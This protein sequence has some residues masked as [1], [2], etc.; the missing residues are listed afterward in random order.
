MTPQEAPKG[1]PPVNQD[2]YQDASRWSSQARGTGAMA[3]APS[4]TQD[5]SAQTGVDPDG[6]ARWQ[7]YLDPARTQDNLRSVWNDPVGETQR[8]A[9]AFSSLPLDMK[10]KHLDTYAQGLQARNELGA[11]KALMSRV[12]GLDA[13][14]SGFTQ[15]F[16]NLFGAFPEAGPK[17]LSLFQDPLKIPVSSVLPDGS[18]QNSALDGMSTAD[19][20]MTAG[21]KLNHLD[22]LQLG[23]S[24][25]PSVRET[26]K[27]YGELAQIGGLGRV[28][29][30]FTALR[31]VSGL[32][33]DS[34]RG[35]GMLSKGARAVL[36]AAAGGTEANPVNPFMANVGPMAAHGAIGGGIQNLRNFDAQLAKNMQGVYREPGETYQSRMEAEGGAWPRILYGLKGAAEGGASGAAAGA[37]FW[38]AGHIVR[39]TGK[40]MFMP[41]EVRGIEGEIAKALGNAKGT[42][43]QKIGPIVQANPLLK[44]QANAIGQALEWVVGGKAV[45]MTASLITGKPPKQLAEL[46]ENP[47]ITALVGYAWGTVG[48]ALHGK[49]LEEPKDLSIDKLAEWYDS[50]APWFMKGAGQKLTEMGWT[51]EQKV[52]AARAMRAGGPQRDIALGNVFQALTNKASKGAGVGEKTTVIPPL[53]NPPAV[54]VRPDEEPA[55]QGETIPPEQAARR[56]RAKTDTGFRAANR[57]F[58][59]YGPE[60]TNGQSPDEFIAGVKQKT[61]AMWQHAQEAEDAGDTKTATLLRRT[62]DLLTRQEDLSR[63]ERAELARNLDE[64]D[65]AATSE[66]FA[67]RMEQ[68]RLRNAREDLAAAEQRAQDLIRQGYER[69]GFVQPELMQ[70]LKQIQEAMKSVAK[71]EIPPGL[72]PGPRKRPRME[73]PYTWEPTFRDSTSRQ[74]PPEGPPP[75]RPSGIPAERRLPPSTGEGESGG[76]PGPATP[77]E[78]RTPEPATSAG[79]RAR[80]P[81]SSL[82]QELPRFRE[83]ITLPKDLPGRRAY[84]QLALPAGGET[85]EE[86]NRR[87]SDERRRETRPEDVVRDTAIAAEEQQRRTMTAPTPAEAVT[88]PKSMRVLR[89]MVKRRLGS[90][91]DKADMD[92]VPANQILREPGTYQFRTG[93]DK[94]NG[95]TKRVG[96][97]RPQS[98]GVI[99]LH[100]RE[101]GTLAVVNGHNRL[102]S[103]DRAV[104]EGKAQADDPMLAMIYKPSVSKQEAYAMGILQNMRD[105]QFEPEEAARAIRTLMPDGADGLTWLQ[106]NGI[107]IGTKARA[108]VSLAKL[109]GSVFSDVIDNILPKELGVEIGRLLPEDHAAQRQI[110]NDIMAM[111][112]ETGSFPTL[113]SLRQTIKKAA[114]GRE[115]GAEIQVDRAQLARDSA[116]DEILAAVRNQLGAQRA[117]AKRANENA[118]FLEG[119]GKNKIDRE[120]NARKMESIQQ[121][122]DAAERLGRYESNLATMLNDAAQ[123][124]IRDRSSMPTIVQQVS[125]R[126][127]AY[128]PVKDSFKGG[129]TIPFEP[130]PRQETASMFG[131]EEPA[132]LFDEPSGQPI[133]TAAKVASSPE[134]LRARVEGHIA[135]KEYPQ[136]IAAAEELTGTDRTRALAMV[137]AAQRRDASSGKRKK[138]AAAGPVEEQRAEE[139]AAAPV[140]PSDRPEA[141]PPE[142]VGDIALVSARASEFGRAELENNAIV[143]RLDETVARTAA[144]LSAT[145]TPRPQRPGSGAGLLRGLKGSK[146]GGWGFNREYAPHPDGGTRTGRSFWSLV[147]DLTEQTGAIGPAEAWDLASTVYGAPLGGAAD[148]LPWSSARPFKQLTGRLTGTG[149]LGHLLS[150]RTPDDNVRRLLSAEERARLD[151][152]TPEAYPLAQARIGALAADAARAHAQE[153]H[154]A[155]VGGFE[156]GPLNG[157]HLAELG[158]LVDAYGRWLKVAADR[159]YNVVLPVVRGTK[160]PRRAWLEAM[161]HNRFGYQTSGR[162]ELAATERK[163]L[164]VLGESGWAADGLPVEIGDILP[165]TSF[166]RLMRANEVVS[167][168]LTNEHLAGYAQTVNDLSSGRS[169]VESLNALTD[170]RMDPKV[171]SDIVE[172]WRAGDWSELARLGVG[173]STVMR[174]Q[175]VG[176]SERT[177]KSVPKIEGAEKL[178]FLREDPDS[179][180]FRKRLA[181]IEA[182]V[183]EIVRD[184]AELSPAKADPKWEGRLAD[185]SAAD[186]LS[187][188]REEIGTVPRELFVVNERMEA[189]DEAG[190]R[191]AFASLLERAQWDGEV[192]FE[193]IDRALNASTGHVASP[194]HAEA[195]NAIRSNLAMMLDHVRTHEWM[196]DRDGSIGPSNEM[197][198]E[199]MKV[200]RARGREEQRPNPLYEGDN[201]FLGRVCQ[202]PCAKFAETVDETKKEKDWGERINTFASRL[203]KILLSD[204]QTRAAFVSHYAEQIVRP[205]GWKFVNSWLKNLFAS[206]RNRHGDTLTN[207]MSKYNEERLDAF[208]AWLGPVFEAA[209]KA[210]Y[211]IRSNFYERGVDEP[212]TPDALEQEREL[213]LLSYALEGVDRNGNR[214]DDNQLPERARKAIGPM[215][216]TYDQARKFIAQHI[217]RDL[218]S[219]A[220]TALRDGHE[221]PSSMARAWR[222]VIGKE[223]DPQK[224]LDIL[225]ATWSTQA[226]DVVTVHGQEVKGWGLRDYHPH[227][228]SEKN[229]KGTLGRSIEDPGQA[230]DADEEAKPAPGTFAEGTKAEK[231][232]V[233]FTENYAVAHGLMPKRILMRNLLERLEGKD[234]YVPDALWVMNQYLNRMVD[235][236]YYERLIDD[237]DPMMFGRFEA[238]RTDD[239]DNLKQ[240]LERVPSEGTFERHGALGSVEGYFGA[241]LRGNVMRAKYYTLDNGKWIEGPSRGKKADKDKLGSRWRAD[242]WRINKRFTRL[243]G[244]PD[245]WSIGLSNGTETLVFRGKKAIEKAGIHVRQNGLTNYTQ[246]RQYDAMKDF[247]RRATGYDMETGLFAEGDQQSAIAKKLAAAGNALNEIFYQAT[248]GG[249]FNTK[250]WAVQQMEGTVQNVASLGAQTFADVVPKFVGYTQFMTHV[251]SAKDPVAARAE[252]KQKFADTAYVK[253]ALPIL[254]AAKMRIAHLMRSQVESDA[255]S[256]GE[257]VAERLRRTSYLAFTMAD[258]QQKEMA[259]VAAY[260]KAMDLGEWHDPRTGKVLKIV[261]E[262]VPVGEQMAKWRGDYISAHDVAR[263][264]MERT[265]FT[266]PRWAQPG[267]MRLPGWSFVGHLGTQATNITAEFWH[268]LAK[269]YD[270]TK[271]G[272]EA[273]L[274]MAQK[275][276]RYMVGL[277]AAYWIGKL[278]GR[279]LGSYVGSHV[280]EIGIGDA[281]LGRLFPVL[282]ALPDGVRVPGW[283]LPNK[284]SLPLNAVFSPEPDVGIPA[285]VGSSMLRWMGGEEDLPEAM[286]NSLRNWWDKNAQT[287][288]M[289]PFSRFGRPLVGAMTANRSDLDPDRPYQVRDPWW[290][291]RDPK[292]RYRNAFDLYFGDIFLPGWSYHDSAEQR[293]SEW[294]AALTSGRQMVGSDLRKQLRAPD[295]E[296]ARSAYR[297]LVERGFRVDEWRNR[298]KAILDSLPSYVRRRIPDGDMVTKLRTYADL[299]GSWEPAFRRLALRYI[300]PESGKIPD[301]VSPELWSAVMRAANGDENAAAP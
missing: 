300:L 199:V 275:A 295:E 220:K 4:P 157:T 254:E 146:E 51:P 182:H 153:V 54:A 68:V 297:G 185:V 114:A 271:T 286:G 135:A 40:A 285:M 70:R 163:F 299:A 301:N 31:K 183:P 33:A 248:L 12:N 34:I 200:R 129:V 263:M 176:G 2:L 128:D 92:M 269:A 143:G 75:G 237:L 252:A 27:R 120:A 190:A 102:A 241:K 118:G 189:G 106:Q 245:K 131:S 198:A 219:A 168:A 172:A 243:D 117:A 294:A 174:R 193:W 8:Y 273:N 270:Y 238:I 290:F 186:D 296:T 167:G 63:D 187:L 76:A 18:V 165:F 231:W 22:E 213:Q 235:K 218:V 55:A 6:P 191:L 279:D 72:E 46:T 181:E 25:D 192:G 266:M 132:G 138:K 188:A 21:A 140:L 230:S 7:A 292:T 194:V 222:R 58:E 108:A 26:I 13:G 64:A 36:A 85:P 261:P 166:D 204:R 3:A 207:L 257:R 236:V 59:T 91:A 195:A 268:G 264:V 88:N 14:V 234:G 259:Y 16:T 210:G 53:K 156:R 78:P 56:E 289:G 229:D 100:R 86:A 148:G 196:V 101:D 61:D 126:L 217:F 125:E 287:I 152:T 280:S 291:G 262:Y 144:D 77:P 47:L 96:E 212:T 173:T 15:G 49:G 227:V 48:G 267:L 94:K 242:S 73:K 205:E 221:L 162:A 37:M 84:T 142:A 288:G 30:E 278:I 43:L 81:S 284:A 281:T 232:K 201:D 32:A 109:E 99:D 179:H 24:V 145:F 50:K 52:E 139:A 105:G 1:S 214:F 28:I 97:W 161:F 225:E 256:G 104:A 298:K 42:I 65:K 171:A 149:M 17:L 240:A 137:K 82:P 260:H 11:I 251:L 197:M 244:D 83:N 203:K 124:L 127:A 103:H 60:A 62:V 71:G 87:L 116:R 111:A 147:D 90:D 38:A 57:V 282:K 206:S 112:Q 136:A 67:G 23:S 202:S 19:A 233:R 134:E 5:Q 20:I 44:N 130:A 141:P 224:V 274:W 216:E 211:T 29:A 151:W 164:D 283:Q 208:H 80:A 95:D 113:E 133:Q 177:P 265:H 209:K 250:A 9:R 253:E 107:S 239:P 123:K 35:S 226:G 184:L 158:R 39:G 228:W 249:V 178:E 45:D 272:N 115:V 175:S 170:M 122:L 293:R 155:K 154:D 121:T 258:V 41:P 277:M 119:I 160:S 159:G 255:M 98:A 223:R 180:H 276:T 93:G 246:G 89:E 79:R 74:A 215:R 150:E 110:R 69:S 247:V 66:A 169:M 10:Q